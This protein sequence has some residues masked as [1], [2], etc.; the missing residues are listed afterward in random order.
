MLGRVLVALAGGL[1]VWKYRDSLRE[2]LGGNA[3]P[4]RAKLDELLQ[5]VQ[6]KSEG[7]LDQAKE[8]L[9]SRIG[10][11]RERVRAG[12]SAADARESP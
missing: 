12:G 4:A 1:V 10:G 6:E 3:G 8:Q 9:S 2:Y 5:T 11:A 7:L